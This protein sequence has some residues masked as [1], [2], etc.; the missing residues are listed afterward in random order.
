MNRLFSKTLQTEDTRAHAAFFLRFHK[1]LDCLFSR[2]FGKYEKKQACFQK[3][4]KK[5]KQ[6]KKK[7]QQGN[8]NLKSCRAILYLPLSTPPSPSSFSFLFK[9]PPHSLHFSLSIPLPLYPPLFSPLSFSLITSFL[10]Y[11]K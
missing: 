4:I 8:K 9:I 3:W 2:M 5:T 10:C 7:T 6:N 11:R 1:H